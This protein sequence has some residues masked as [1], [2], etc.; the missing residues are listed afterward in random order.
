[1]VAVPVPVIDSRP[2]EFAAL[3]ANDSDAEVAPLDCGVKVTAKDAD[4][5]A[6]SV[7]GSDIPETTNSALLMPA[8]V[9]LTGEPLAVIVPLSEAVDPTAT[10]PKLRVAG[11]S[12]NWPAAAPVP[13]NATLSVEFDA[14]DTMDKPPVFVPP[15]VGAK[16]ALKVTL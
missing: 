10:L 13:E 15:L 12:P 1:M 11:D 14:L 4:W 6:E 16:I 8:D 3:L 5:P 2:G 9:M 7:T